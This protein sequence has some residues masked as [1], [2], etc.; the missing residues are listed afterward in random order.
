MASSIQAV[1]LIA[2]ARTILAF[3]VLEVD[4]KFLTEGKCL[5]CV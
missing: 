3:L 1:M 5:L 4:V 2:R